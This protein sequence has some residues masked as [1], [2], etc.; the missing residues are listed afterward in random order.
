M[1]G[2]QAVVVSPV[3]TFEEMIECCATLLPRLTAKVMTP[4]ARVEEHPM[5]MEALW[6]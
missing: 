4:A 2:M 3:P 6:K 1:R 5:R